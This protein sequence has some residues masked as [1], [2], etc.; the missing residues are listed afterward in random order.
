M[1]PRGQTDGGTTS[2]AALGPRDGARERLTAGRAT[3]DAL[4]ALLDERVLYDRPIA[5]RHRVIFYVGHLEAFDANLPSPESIVRQILLGSLELERSVGRS[6]DDL[7]LPDCF[8]FPRSLPTVAAH[9]GVVGF[10]TQ[11]LRRGSEMRAAHGI[12]FAL[13]RWR[14]P[15]PSASRRRPSVCWPRCFTAS[16]SR[17]RQSGRD[18]VCPAAITSSNP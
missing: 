18:T 10:L 2:T 5:E 12:P 1:T 14:G 6:S 13:G 11:K 7:F 15:K 8:G 16:V 17:T 4:F 3:T 9:C